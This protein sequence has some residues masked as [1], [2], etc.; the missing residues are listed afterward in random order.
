MRIPRFF[1]GGLIGATIAVAVSGCS[2]EP[3]V[4]VYGELVDRC[5]TN[6]TT[7]DSSTEGYRAIIGITLANDSSREVILREVTPL[8][9]VNAVVHDIAVT[10]THSP[11][12]M[13]GVAPGGRLIPEQR[14][15]WNARTAVDGVRIPGGGAAE[16]L[17]TLVAQDFS[18]YSGIEGL[19]VKY[20]DGWF[21]ELAVGAPVIGFVPPWSGCTSHH[22]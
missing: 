22:R 16:V 15:L 8:T 10:S 19:R 1:A 17:V 3:A 20:D 14:P 7:P 6:L 12:T 9:V 11:A 2:S 5:F 18:R 21:S 4:Q 13:F